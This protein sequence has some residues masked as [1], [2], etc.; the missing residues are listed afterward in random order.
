MPTVSTP[1][2]VWVASILT[3]TGTNQSSSIY[4]TVNITAG[5]EIQI[6]IQ[7]IMSAVSSDPVVNILPSMDGGANYDT[8]AFQ[9]FSIARITGGG[10]VQGSIRLS[11]GQYLIQMTSSGP[12]SQSFALLTQLVLTS[13]N[14]V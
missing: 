5:W 11:T 8:S 13:I 1:V 7:V 2:S 14:N 6:P 3:S 9:S 4:A 10:T 12:N